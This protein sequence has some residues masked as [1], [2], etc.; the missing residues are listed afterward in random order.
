MS[1]LL[2]RRIHP[3]F[4]L[5]ELV[6]VLAVVA[7]VAAIAV[8]TF[9]TVRTN[10]AAQVA[11]ASA[12]AVARNAFALATSRAGAGAVSTAQFCESLKDSLDESPRV[13]LDDPTFDCELS[14]PNEATWIVRHDNGNVV[15]VTFDGTTVT[16][17]SAQGGGGG[18]FFAPEV[19]FT[20]QPGETL[21]LPGATVES[22]DQYVGVDF[23]Q[24]LAGSPVWFGR[25]GPD[26]FVSN[27]MNGP[28][29]V[30][31]AAVYLQ[32]FGSAPASGTMVF[33]GVQPFGPGSGQ[34][35]DG[36]VLAAAKQGD[37][38]IIGG[39][40]TSIAGNAY[41]GVAR[42]NAD[43][44]LDT[45]FQNPGLD[46]VSYGPPGTLDGV[47]AL[48]VQ[49]DGKILVGG[50]LARTVGSET[51]QGD[52]VR[53]NSD[54]SR[55]T[56]WNPTFPTQEVWNGSE[57]VTV[58]DWIGGWVQSMAVDASGR[59][60]VGGHF[61]SRV[62]RL[63]ATGELDSGF[64]DVAFTG[65]FGGL[66]YS[67]AVDASDRVLIGGTFDSVDGATRLNVARL[68]TSGTLD[69][70]FVPASVNDVVWVVAPTPDGKVVIGGQFDTVGAQSRAA[71]VARLNANGT[72]DTSFVPD[73]EGYFG[74]QV[75]A[76]RVLSDGKV[77]VSN[78][79]G[80]L[81]A[82]NPISGVVQLNGD[83]SWN[84]GVT[85]WFGAADAMLPLADNGTLLLGT[86]SF[87]G[88][89]FFGRVSRVDVNGLGPNTVTVDYTLE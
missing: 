68:D 10:A 81:H 76:V 1:T 41:S 63:T 40:F 77:V 69:T 25:G 2:N 51:F 57:V 85:Y 11:E 16:V 39:N 66:V 30:D 72:L 73:I 31:P 82:G 70:S 4:S 71:G 7:L 64:A 62:L 49:P 32:I 87:D 33:E 13:E 8:P 20:A 28:F 34:A 58:T 75:M 56:G 43:G 27:P 3:G 5:V 59:V 83:G 65:E 48:A 12:E 60:V 84:Q 46:L 54:G 6:V 44:T 80:F 14:D 50:L 74:V 45:S 18:G 89:S 29:V 53:L 86:A 55:D 35:I 21:V 67:V 88:V 9:S 78:S 52:L 26:L 79:G 24:V 37:K 22:G 15:P 38:T 17:G 19:T 47:A 23:S 61:P 42:L 36:M